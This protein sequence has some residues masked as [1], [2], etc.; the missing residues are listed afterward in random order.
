MAH[1]SLHPLVSATSVTSPPPHS[2]DYRL[3]AA[4]A[5]GQAHQIGQVDAFLADAR[6]RE[7]S[8]PIVL[9]TTDSSRIV[10]AAMLVESPGKSA[11]A[12]FSCRN[13]SRREDAIALLRELRRIAESRRI[14]LLEMLLEPHELQKSHVAGEVGFTRLTQLEYL[15]RVGSAR[16]HPAV[17]IPV[18]KWHPYSEESHPLFAASIQRSYA[19]SQD[20]PE[21]TSLRRIDDVLADHRAAGE[22]DPALWQVALCDGVPCGVILLCRIQNQPA[23]ELVYMGVTPEAR[24]KGIG[25]ALLARANELATTTARGGAPTEPLDI[26]LAVDER[27]SPAKRLYS[28]WGYR[29][30]GARV[31]MIATSPATRG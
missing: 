30:I 12:F 29:F 26:V 10:E 24:G 19:Q 18:L 9:T 2:A 7:L 5:L 14:L 15:R 8:T 21:L 25:D 11:L 27:N 1:E 22:F 28:R 16:I 3:A 23:L 4:I 13:A 6:R 20:C 31:A 17:Q